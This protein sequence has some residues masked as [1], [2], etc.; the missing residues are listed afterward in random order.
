MP[1][2]QDLNF[3]KKRYW[4]ERNSDSATKRVMR[5]LRRSQN[6]GPAVTGPGINTHFGSNRK[7][8]RKRVIDRSFTTPDRN[9]PPHHVFNDYRY[10]R[11]VKHGTNH[12]R[13]K[14]RQELRAR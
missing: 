11:P 5:Q 9:E 8:D 6:I 10:Q 4:D 12:E 2:Y 14:A 13:M 7:A 3:D 1:K